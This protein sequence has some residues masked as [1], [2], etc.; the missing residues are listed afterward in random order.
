MLQPIS[1]FPETAI[2]SQETFTGSLYKFMSNLPKKKNKKTLE[3]G[4][5]AFKIRIKNVMLYSIISVSRFVSEGGE[6]QN[7]AH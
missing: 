5:H 1:Y 2:F 4:A 6:D 7:S 3:Q